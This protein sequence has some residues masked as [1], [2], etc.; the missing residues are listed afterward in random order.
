[1]VWSAW[2][3]L[4]SATAFSMLLG[5]RSYSLHRLEL[6]TPSNML[7]LGRTPHPQL[8]CVKNTQTSNIVWNAESRRICWDRGSKLLKN[9][10]MQILNLACSWRGENSLNRLEIGQHWICSCCDELLAQKRSGVLHTVKRETSCDPKQVGELLTQMLWLAQKRLES[11]P[12]SSMLLRTD[13]KWVHHVICSYW[14][15][16]PTH[17]LHVLKTLKRAT[18]PEMLQVRGTADTDG[19]ICSKRTGINHYI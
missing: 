18:S 17:N 15:K 16:L 19:P 10:Q 13:W 9:N 7:L 12:A 11:A 2:K 5:E 1:M 3:R 6:G 8:A 4:E 14:D